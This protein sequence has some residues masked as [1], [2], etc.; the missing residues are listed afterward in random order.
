M[1]GSFYVAI[2]LIAKRRFGLSVSISFSH[3]KSYLISIKQ[4]RH[5]GIIYPIETCIKQVKF[6]IF[7]TPDEHKI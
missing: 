2:V 6:H 4:K 7:T 1:Q 3:L 5:F